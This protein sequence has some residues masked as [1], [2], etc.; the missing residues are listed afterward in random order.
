MIAQLRGTVEEIEGMSVIVGV[1]GVGY[2]VFC[3]SRCRSE[4]SVASEV[5][6]PIFTEVKEDA[7]R[8]YGFA[9]KT[10][11]QVFLLLNLVKG[12]G[13][14]SALDIISKIDAK[15]LLRIISKG[16]L[17]KLSGIKGLGKKTAERIIV[18]LKDKVGNFAVEQGSGQLLIEKEITSEPAH[19]ALLALQALGFTK[20]DAQRAL[21]QISD[22]ESYVESGLIVRDALR[23]I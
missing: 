15:E 4:L 6:L 19:E 13:P 8:L 12:I 20:K 23:H 2:Q 10:E 14:K 11:K 9:D 17:T 16:D 3:S 22:I 1:G 5:T 7:I 21:S 18:E